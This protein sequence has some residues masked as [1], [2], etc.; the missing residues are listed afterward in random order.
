LRNLAVNKLDTSRA[1][2]LTNVK[3]LQAADI[4]STSPPSFRCF[5]RGLRKGRRSCDL[6]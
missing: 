2:P 5:M 1:A 3:V 6:L 4:R